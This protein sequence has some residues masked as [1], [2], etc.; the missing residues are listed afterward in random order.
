MLI[1]FAATCDVDFKGK[2]DSKTSHMDLTFIIH[3]DEEDQ[4]YF[5]EGI[6]CSVSEMPSSQIQGY[7]LQKEDLG[8][9]Y[10]FDNG[11]CINVV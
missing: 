1:T 4:N 2:D 6:K 9:Q 3:F 5:G 7:A 8:Q 10:K 11:L